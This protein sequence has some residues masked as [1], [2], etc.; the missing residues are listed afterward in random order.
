MIVSLLL[1]LCLDVVSQE[2]RALEDAA[3]KMLSAPKSAVSRCCLLFVDLRFH[4][5]PASRCGSSHNMLQGVQL[6][7]VSLVTGLTTRGWCS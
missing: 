1:F 7:G 4:A 5:L 2:E 3:K 6:G